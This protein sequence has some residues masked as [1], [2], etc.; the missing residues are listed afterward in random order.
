MD[1]CP[2]ANARSNYAGRCRDLVAPMTPRA[3]GVVSA[4]NSSYSL[5]GRLRTKPPRREQSRQ[6]ASVARVSASARLPYERKNR[7]GVNAAWMRK[8]VVLVR[9]T[10]TV[11]RSGLPAMA[12]GHG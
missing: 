6:N 12:T 3:G 2:N 4:E 10:V 9:P 1:C 7:G 11:L 8:R 5:A